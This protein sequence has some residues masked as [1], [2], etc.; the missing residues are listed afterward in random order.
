MA[1][2]AES[3]A[4]AGAPEQE[5]YHILMKDISRFLEDQTGISSFQAEGLANGII[6]W[7]VEEL[8]DAAKTPA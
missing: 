2:S 5:K 3:G 8:F 7:V 6:A 4:E 1:A